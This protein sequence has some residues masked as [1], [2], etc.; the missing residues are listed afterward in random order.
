M[1]IGGAFLSCFF[2]FFSL[3]FS[4]FYFLLNTVNIF[5]V[6]VAKLDIC[7]MFVV[8]FQYV[9]FSS[10]LGFLIDLDSSFLLLFLSSFLWKWLFGLSVD[11]QFGDVVAGFVYS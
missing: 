4:F 6:F 7:S 1:A 5:F 10:L 2:L 11:F 8:S 9:C 3:V